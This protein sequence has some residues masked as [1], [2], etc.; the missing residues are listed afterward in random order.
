M[1]ENEKNYDQI[2]AALVLLATLGVIAFNFLASTGRLNNTDTGAISD[3]Y[4]TVVTPAGYAFSIWSLIYLGL[5]AFSVYQMIPSKV[6]GFRGIRT[7]YLL[8]CVL[9]CAWLYAWHHYWIGACV[10]LIFGLLATLALI[11]IRLADKDR[12]LDL[13]IAK[14]PFGIYFGWVTAASFVNLLIYFKYVGVELSGPSWNLVGIAII[15]V[16]LLAASLVRVKLRS[17]VYPLSVAWALTAIAIKQSG[18]T[19]I[20]LA[21]AIAVILCLVLTL[22]FVMDLRHSRR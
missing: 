12:G 20:I 19:S 1:A 3:Q 14:A 8:T 9:N 13:V 5:V 7:L 2:R 11:N 21:A 22:S 15:V 16:V 4:P 18:N 17:F 6:A 10:M